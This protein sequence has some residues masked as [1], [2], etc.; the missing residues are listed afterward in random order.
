[1]VKRTMFEVFIRFRSGF[2]DEI[3]EEIFQCTL[4]LAFAVALML[5]S[6]LMTRELLSKRE[7][8][9]STGDDPYSYMV[10]SKTCVMKTPERNGYPE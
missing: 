7:P 9:H 5:C 4:P 6:L 1:M 3:L 10:D 2:Y 8:G